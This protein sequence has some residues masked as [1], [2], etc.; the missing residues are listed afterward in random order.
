VRQIEIFGNSYPAKIEAAW[1]KSRDGIF[2]VGR[3][4]IQAKAELPH[5]EFEAMI[6]AELP[7]GPSTARRIKAIAEDAW[8]AK[9]AHVNVL[10]NN[11][12]T[13]Y[14]LT[15]VPVEDRDRGIVE[16]II[17]PDMERR[18]VA[19]LPPCLPW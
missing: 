3:L 12:G 17:R 16:G 19:R 8:L 13:L 18:D 5:G 1:N 9:R 6:E 7:F 4:L 11:W 14:Q 10:P 15:T 2:E